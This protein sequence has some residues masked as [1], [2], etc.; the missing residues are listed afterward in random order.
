MIEN[1]SFYSVIIG[2]ELLNGRREDSHFAFLRQELNDRG[3]EYRG[4]FVI[5][6]D[7]ALI[8]ETFAF[9][10]KDPRA[11]LFSFG[12]IGA[13]PDDYTRKAA[14]AVFGKGLVR[15]KEAERIILETFGEEAYPHRIHMADLPENAKLLYNP[16][17]KVPGFYLED[18]WFFVPGFPQMARPMV[19]EALD[20][21]YPKNR[22]KKSCSFVAQVSENALIDIM[23]QLPEDLELSCLPKLEG[24]RRTAEIYLADMDE[25]RLQKWCRFFKEQMKLRSIEWI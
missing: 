17:T 20:R 19:I 14:G 21:L 22:R 24:Q 16:V 13:T 10:K 2:T 23:Q 18:R 11:V 3:W 4:S 5:K 6:D 25:K 7:P 12:G 15:H 1:P 9:I 8:E